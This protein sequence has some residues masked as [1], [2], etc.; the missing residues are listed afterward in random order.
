[1][2]QGLA[3][4]APTAIANI[5]SLVEM[6]GNCDFCSQLDQEKALFIE[7]AANQLREGVSAFVERRRPPRF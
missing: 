7:Y 4:G 1:M 5:K 6:A 3:E 2:A